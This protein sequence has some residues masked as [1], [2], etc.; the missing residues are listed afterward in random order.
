MR[1]TGRVQ[2]DCGYRHILLAGANPSFKKGLSDGLCLRGSADAF[3]HRVL[4]RDHVQL[5]GNMAYD[6]VSSN[7]GV[8]EAGS[9]YV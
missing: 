7:S 1:G 6:P 3:K 5:A 4:V 2:L 9:I 8:V